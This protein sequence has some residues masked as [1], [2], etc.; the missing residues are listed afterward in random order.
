MFIK[1][2]KKCGS[3]NVV[4]FY[5]CKGIRKHFFYCYLLA[6]CRRKFSGNAGVDIRS[7][8]GLNCNKQKTDLTIIV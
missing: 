7:V 6:V 2:K 5:F 4:L 3:T 1:K 8:F